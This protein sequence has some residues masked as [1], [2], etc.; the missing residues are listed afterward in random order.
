MVEIISPINTDHSISNLD[1]TD[2]TLLSFNSMKNNHDTLIVKNTPKDIPKWHFAMLNDHERNLA[3]EQAIQSVDMKGKC[4]LDIGTGS[5]LLSMLAVKNGAEHVYTCESNPSVAAH[6]INIIRDNQMQDRIT[7][8]NKL[9]LYL[10][11]GIDLPKNLDVLISE[12]VD[13]GFFGEGFGISLPHAQANLLAPD[14]QLIPKKVKLKAQLLSSSRIFNL[15]TVGNTLGFN[16]TRFNQLATKSYFPVRLNTWHHHLISDQVAFYE[17][18][19]YDST[20]F[21]ESGTLALPI[22]LDGYIHGILFWFELYLTDEIVLTNSPANPNSHWMQ[23]VQ[24]FEKPIWG[25]KGDVYHF[26]YNIT[27]STV[28][29]SP[30]K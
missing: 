14:A 28:F 29:F 22:R 19:F 10:K 23:A 5:G 17:R 25:E 16:I 20:E 3:F 24:T 8:I 30:K 9:S 21:S 1:L 2:R 4:V 7:V 26:H 27:D 13:C 15:N 12:T 18:D 11:P 6:A